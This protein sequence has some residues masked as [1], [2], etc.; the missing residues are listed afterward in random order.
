MRKEFSH[1]EWCACTSLTSHGLHLC[2]TPPAQVAV[3]SFGPL[4]V[5]LQT[6]LL[7]GI[8]EKDIHTGS[9]M[10]TAAG[11][12]GTIDSAFSH[13]FIF[14]SISLL[15]VPAN[16]EGGVRY[17]MEME[18]QYRFNACLLGMSYIPVCS[19]GLFT[20]WFGEGLWREQK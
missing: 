14:S 11:E 10:G 17:A 3:S 15:L 5:A 19:T 4:V 12:L 6:L 18:M 2:R 1:A 16:L 9:L 20:V 13:A 7:S 8:T